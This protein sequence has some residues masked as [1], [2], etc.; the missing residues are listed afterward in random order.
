MGVVGPVG[1]VGLVGLVGLVG[2]IRFLLNLPQVPHVL[3]VPQVLPVL[4]NFLPPDTVD[5]NVDKLK[6]IINNVLIKHVALFVSE[7]YIVDNILKRV[8]KSDVDKLIW[9]YGCFFVN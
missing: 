9:R 7:F 2:T 1:P 4:H 6:I 8:L 3:P 5:F